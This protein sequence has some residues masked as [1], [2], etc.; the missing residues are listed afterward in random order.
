MHTIRH[1]LSHCAHW[2]H[3]QKSY[4]LKDFDEPSHREL[5]VSQVS[6]YAGEKPAE[7]VAEVRAALLDGKEFSDEVMKL[8]LHYSGG[9]SK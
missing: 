5:A 4:M 8:Y 1:E 7:F 3:D 9:L 6:M 2:H